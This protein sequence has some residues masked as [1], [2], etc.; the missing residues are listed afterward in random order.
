MG[1]KNNSNKDRIY[2]DPVCGMEVSY[3]TAP[4]TAIY[5]KKEYFFC[6]EVCRRA[7]EEDPEQYIHK[8][9]KIG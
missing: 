6:A 9:R 2:K 3:K 5:Q 7:F 8:F 1:K 4:E